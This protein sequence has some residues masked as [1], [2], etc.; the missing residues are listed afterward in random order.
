MEAYAVRAAESDRQHG[1]E[2]TRELRWNQAEAWHGGW[3]VDE[4]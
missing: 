2:V 4:L 1:A 3:E